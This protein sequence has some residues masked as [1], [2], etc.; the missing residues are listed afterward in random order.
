MAV[1]LDNGLASD[2]GV[3]S[4]D[5]FC[6]SAKLTHERDGKPPMVPDGWNALPM[7]STA[8]WGERWFLYAPD[9]NKVATILCSP[10]SPKIPAL[11]ANVQIANRYLYF[12]DFKE[13]CNL[14][15]ES[16]NLVPIGLSRIDLC[17]DFEMSEGRYETYMAL[18]KKNARVKGVRE[19][20]SWWKSLPEGD[21]S[22]SSR[23][24]DV[25]NQVNWGG[26]ESTFH[27]K[28]YYKWLELK[29]AAPDE[30]KPWILD[31][32]RYWGLREKY[33]WRCEVS[34][35]HS[36]GL[37]VWDG[38]MLTPFDWFDNR[39]QLFCDLYKDKVVIREKQ[40]HADRRND[41]LLP[42]LDIDGEKSVKH[43]LPMTSRDDSDPERRLVCK[44]WS[45]LQQSDTQCNKDVRELIQQT[46]LRLMERPSNVWIIQRMFG[47]DATGIA[48]AL[49]M[50]I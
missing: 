5:W 12:D 43:A 10:R 17:C 26:Q 19:S 35:S 24:V 18:A 49:D 6:M 15:L 2:T 7:S 30:Q 21:G 37:R 34:I 36:N 23:L 14:V 42:F 13:V 39:V 25:P 31:T 28:I 38:K 16:L 11:S 1:Y 9:G 50:P 20:V 29:N 45:E 27:W 3:V 32:W 33:V 41:R 40:G 46:L 22:E 47:V 4:C 48:K 44:L 8:V